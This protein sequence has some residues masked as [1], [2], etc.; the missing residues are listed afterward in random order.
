MISLI[1]ATVC[2]GSVCFSH[3]AKVCKDPLYGTHEP[4]DWKVSM[5]KGAT[6]TKHVIDCYDWHFDNIRP[7]RGS[8]VDKFMF[9]FC[10]GRTPYLTGRFDDNG[11]P[12]VAY[13][14]KVNK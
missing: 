5:V 7:G 8:K 4:C 12:I 6:V 14:G 13:N 10:E 1:L 2:Y 9:D 3:V 11:K